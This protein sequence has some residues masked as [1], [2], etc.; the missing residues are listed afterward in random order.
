MASQS[1]VPYSDTVS[2]GR[3]NLSGSSGASQS[4]SSM[5]AYDFDRTLQQT[6]ANSSRVTGLAV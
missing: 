4:M 5:G 3:K 6:L 1:G 2:G